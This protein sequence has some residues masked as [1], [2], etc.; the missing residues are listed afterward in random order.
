MF[1]GLWQGFGPLVLVLLLLWSWR[2]PLLRLI[3]V[4]DFL[5]RRRRRRLLRPRVGHLL[6]VAGL[7]LQSRRVLAAEVLLPDFP[8]GRA[9]LLD[10][11]SVDDW[12]DR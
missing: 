4:Q 7:D 8:E 9:E 5:V 2:R 12:V 3:R 10:A 1:S 6:P 11:E